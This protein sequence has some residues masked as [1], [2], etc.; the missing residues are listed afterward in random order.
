MASLVP[1]H[2]LCEARTCS[3]MWLIK[4]VYTWDDENLVVAQ[5]IKLSASRVLTWHWIPGYLGSCWSLL[6]SGSLETLVLI[7]VSASNQACGNREG[8]QARGKKKS[9]FCHT[10]FL[11]GLHLEGT[12][13]T[14]SRSLHINQW[15][16][17]IRTISQVRF[18]AH[19]I[20]ICDKLTLKPTVRAALWPGFYHF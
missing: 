15:I 7:T 18:P 14:W 6:N 2:C 19:V 16:K 12:V 10:I 20:V 13:H 11:S 1:L 8:Q 17:A 3:F 5:C 9:S 4:S